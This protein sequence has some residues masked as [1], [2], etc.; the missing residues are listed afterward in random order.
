MNQ[1]NKDLLKK[2]TCKYTNNLSVEYE[3]NQSH[4]LPQEKYFFSNK[5][6]QST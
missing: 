6:D 2:N 4:S 5:N 1:K 3:I